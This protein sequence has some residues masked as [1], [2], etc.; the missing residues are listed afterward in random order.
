MA[1]KAG[2]FT[3]KEILTQSEAWAESLE[4]V[5]KAGKELKGLIREALSG[6]GFYRLWFNLLPFTGCRCALP[7]NLQEDCMWNH[8]GRALVQSRYG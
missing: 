4:V 8:R 2:Q 5:E 3:E 1:I 6:G 7:A